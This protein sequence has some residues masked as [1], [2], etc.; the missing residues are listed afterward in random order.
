MESVTFAIH[1]AE[2]G[3][4]WAEA[5]G[6]SIS[7]QGDDLNELGAMILDA[8]DGYFFDRPQD[9][10]DEIRWRFRDWRKAA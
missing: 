6:L 4:F 10:P 7:T 3:G 5:D 2:E 8:V 1:P 9:K